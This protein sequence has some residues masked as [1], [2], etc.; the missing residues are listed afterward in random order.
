MIVGES[1]HRVTK[2]IGLVL[3]LTLMSPA[4]GSDAAP[5]DPAQIADRLERAELDFTRAVD[6]V[7]VELALDYGKVRF[8]SGILVP[9]V[10]P[11]EE[12]VIEHV[13][14]GSGRIE[15][16]VDD[17]VEAQ[18]LAYF[19]G[20]EKLEA[21]IR[22]A[23]LIQGSGE[24]NRTLA[25]RP[26][27][28]VAENVR[29]EATTLFDEWVVDAE[30]MGFGAFEAS[31][32]ALADDPVGLG[33]VGIWF[34]SPTLGRGFYRMDPS[35]TEPVSLGMYRLFED[36]DFL[37][38]RAKKR[39]R[40]AD[41]EKKRGEGDEP[42]D[43]EPED[44]K[45]C[46]VLDDDEDYHGDDDEEVY[47]WIKTWMSF[48]R[49]GAAPDQDPAGVESVHYEIDLTLAS[50]MRARGKA[51]IQLRSTAD[52][53]Q[54]ISLRIGPKL[55]ICEI[56]DEEGRPVPFE[57]RGWRVL[58]GLAEA[59]TRGQVFELEV[60][61]AGE[62]IEHWFARRKQRYTRLW[63]PHAGHLDRAT[64]DVTLRW[65]S[66]LALV[67]AGTPKAGGTSDGQSWTQRVVEVPNFG[68]S[69]EVGDFDLIEDHVGHI[70]L[71]FGFHRG[72][73]LLTEAVRTEIIRAVKGSLLFYESQLG[74]L[75]ID[76]MAVVVVE[77]GFSQGLLGFVSLAEG[78][79]H[80]GQGA[81]GEGWTPQEDRLETVAHEI[82]HQWWGHMVGWNSYRDQWLS[83]ALA[84]FSASEFMGQ[85]SGK[86]ELYQRKRARLRRKELASGSFG[87]NPIASFGPVV[88]G[89]RLHSNHG[90]AVY[91]GIVYKKGAAVFSTLAQRLGTQQTWQML[92]ALARQ[93]NNR[94]I[95]TS[96]FFHALERMSGQDLE[97]FVQLFVRGTGIPTLFYDYS[98]R[99]E[100][101][102]GWLVEGRVLQLPSPQYRYVLTPV[103]E[104]WDVVARVPKPPDVASWTNVVPFYLETAKEG[105]SD[106]QAVVG[107]I[108]I[109]GESSEF[110]VP[111]ASPPERFEL[112]PYGQI[113]AELRPD[114]HDQRRNLVELGEHQL[115]IG[116]F[117]EASATLAMALGTA[118]AFAE[119]D[120]EERAGELT[121]RIHLARARLL[122]DRGNQEGAKGELE[123]AEAALPE[124]SEY[125]AGERMILAARLELRSGR[126]S[127]AL[128][129]IND[130]VRRHA[131]ELGLRTHEL[132]DP[133]RMTQLKL[134]RSEV[135][136]VLAIAAYKDGDKD[137]EIIARMA[138]LAGADLRALR[139]FRD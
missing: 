50:D 130:Y 15:V 65:P 90:S 89:T 85:I 16:A 46:G 63:H 106:P 118:P 64:Y 62:P 48:N 4:V 104:N 138:G 10:V 49:P 113:L 105:A 5:P 70:D 1:L 122:L 29:D 81:L 132:P 102:S 111:A 137:A 101:D 116:R 58:A 93:V 94:V 36:E 95:R 55:E 112:D 17:E 8:E 123:A 96:T 117:D 124:D 79:V 47:P 39:A 7:D 52:G 43:E 78:A 56:L 21:P 83:E 131:L 57:Q 99:H 103:G 86:P 119:G 28:E 18:Q 41:R 37:T 128:V 68:F 108:T 92:G 24:L 125:Y 114:G 26:S 115:R 11:D 13:F 100:P 38:H 82:A 27:I 22:N 23:V 73:D 19:T 127:E 134:A 45:E 60:R 61:F 20:Q 2:R 87:G 76:R 6:A 88:L 72:D 126:Y 9:A 53:V 31:I 107:M 54:V 97:G 14:L 34:D 42:R 40:K 12:R 44:S 67:A 25:G 136:A 84:D 33:F 77:R 109:S 139:Q 32:R 3:A 98:A 129:R 80:A 51:R 30:R 121:A 110:V 74:L 91:S 120:S 75:P 133:G 35:R 66:E 69:F 71:S 135:L 59:T